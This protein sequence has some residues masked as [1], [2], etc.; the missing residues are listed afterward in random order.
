[1]KQNKFSKIEF[2]VNKEYEKEVALFYLEKR[3]Y[4]FSRFIKDFPELEKAKKL[5]EKE[6]KEFISKEID[7]IYLAKETELLGKRKEIIEK[8]DK[9]KEAFF[10]ETENLFEHKWPLGE[11]ITNISPFG[12]YRLKLGTKIFSI[13]SNDYAGDPPAF[14]H[15]NFVIIHE[16]LHIFFENYYK[17]HFSD[18]TLTLEQYLHYYDCITNLYL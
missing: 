10:K 8:W 18:E 17:E 7:K 12:M 6:A 15:I 13:P 11:Y 1:M 4:Y 9:V 14:G 16:M 3:E 5:S 2:R